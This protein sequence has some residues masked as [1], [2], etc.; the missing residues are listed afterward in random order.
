MSHLLYRYIFLKLAFINTSQKSDTS[1]SLFSFN[2]YADGYAADRYHGGE[3]DLSATL[4]AGRATIG[5][6]YFEVPV[7]AEKIEIEYETNAFTE[8]KIYFDYDGD[9]DSGYE[10][11]KTAT[12]TENAL[13]VGDT[14]A[15]NTLNMTY[16][17][18]QDDS[19]YHPYI[20]P[21]EG[22]RFVTCEF[23]FENVSKSDVTISGFSF[24]CYADGASCK[25]QYFREDFLS[26]TL[27]PGRK[28]KGTVTF[29]VPADATVVEVEYLTNFWTSSRIVF[30]A[31]AF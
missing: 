28:T 6:L 30:D 1:I 11:E 3:D 29:E 24:D 19:S 31:S 16:L 5:Y 25:A 2:C 9:K 20:A 10:L 4:S 22:Y 14:M 15:G 12:A 13:K 26:A 23:E 8:K 17:A 27:S 21:K 7:D 18:C